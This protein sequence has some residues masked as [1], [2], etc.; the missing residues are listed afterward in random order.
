M[1]KSHKIESTIRY[2]VCGAHD[3]MKGSF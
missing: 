2:I 1:I 3:R